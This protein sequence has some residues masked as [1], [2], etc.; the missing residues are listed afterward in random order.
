MTSFLGRSIGGLFLVNHF[1]GGFL[2]LFFFAGLLK[3]GGGKQRHFVCTRAGFLHYFESKF[4]PQ[5]KGSICL[6]YA[7]WEIR[8]G[9]VCA[10]VCVFL[11][12]QPSL[13]ERSLTYQGPRLPVLSVCKM[14]KMKWSIDVV[15]NLCVKDFSQPKGCVCASYLH[16]VIDGIL[17]ECLSFLQVKKLARWPRLASV[18]ILQGDG[19]CCVYCLYCVHSLYVDCY[20]SIAREEAA[21]QP[22]ECIHLRSHGDR[23]WLHCLCV[24]IGV[25]WHQVF[26]CVLI[27][28]QWHQ[29]FLC[30]EAFS[31][32]LCVCIVVFHRIS[33]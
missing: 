8:D 1:N 14:R 10:L 15:A 7:R 25:H 32:E 19:W 4:D 26:L 16:N 5:P 6:H 17:Y 20:L 28:V 21:P 13:C 31:L 2:A 11:V 29:I 24:L 30:V 18:K 22:I 33:R 9:P 27:G 23:W 3:S 12:A